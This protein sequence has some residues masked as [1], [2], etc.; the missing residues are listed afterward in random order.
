MKSFAWLLVA[1]CITHVW[2]RGIWPQPQQIKVGD[3]QLTLIPSAFKFTTASQSQLL[4]KAIDRYRLLCFPFNTSQYAPNAP[5]VESV[6]I[7]VDS[8]NETLQL[9]FN[10]TYTLNVTESGAVIT[11]GSVFGAMRGLE[12]LAQLIDYDIYNN[13]YT[14][15][16]TPILIVD[17]PRFPWRGIMIDTSRHFIRADVL[18]QMIDAIAFNKMNVFHWH[19]T[20]SHSFPLYSNAYPNLAKKGAYKYPE[21]VYYPENVTR[22]V[23]YGYERGVRVVPEFDMPGHTSAWSKAGYDI[24]VNCNTPN[25]MGLGFT[26][27]PTSNNTWNL[28]DGFFKEQRAQFMDNYFHFGSDEVNLDCW[29]EARI[30]QWKA[31]NGIKS[32]QQLQQYF[33][34]EMVKI[35]DKNGIKKRVFWGDPFIKHGQQFD[36]ENSVLEVWWEYP[37]LER[38]TAAG[39]TAILANGFYLDLQT[40]GTGHYQWTDIWM[41][42]Y[43]NEPLRS[44]NMNDK[45]KSLVIGGECCMWS[46]TVDSEDIMPRV[47]VRSSGAAE[48]LWSARSFVDT[49]I[50]GA[51]NYEQ[52]RGRLIEFRCRLK[53]RGIVAVAIHPDVCP[54]PEELGNP[55]APVTAVGGICPAASIAIVPSDTS[56]PSGPS[57]PNGPSSTINEQ[58]TCN[59]PPVEVTCVCPTPNVTKV[60][61]SCGTES[62]SAVYPVA[63]TTSFTSMEYVYLFGFCLSI[64]SALLTSRASKTVTWNSGF[65]IFV[66]STVVVGFVILM[67]VNYEKIG[68]Q[69]VVMAAAVTTSSMFSL[70][71]ISSFLSAPTQANYPIHSSS[72]PRD[73]LLVVTSTTEIDS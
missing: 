11:A 7:V 41:D 72:G 64:I 50:T 24:T 60:E 34:D 8:A 2:A 17:F 28:L 36:K 31:N 61:V 42:F 63:E 29:N 69:F 13:Y 18:L 71:S 3:K 44:P 54:T 20:D 73:P 43:N 27:D 16:H 19:I 1:M 6:N 47:W 10:E 32:N 14:I 15:E 67:M 70:L 58:I 35:A 23:Q 26:L 57:G 56:V 33:N 66:C 39:Y 49:G 62:T 53:R 40:P 55:M 45:Q 4:K 38:V 65:T 59:C 52:T 5:K 48:R 68:F 21:L 22:I 51:A 25:W 9:G 30:Q 12:S 46:E 37:F